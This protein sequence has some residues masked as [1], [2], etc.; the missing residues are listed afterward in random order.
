[1]IL[2]WFH[3]DFLRQKVGYQFASDSFRTCFF[4]TDIFRIVQLLGPHFLV[5]RKM[6]RK[7]APRKRPNSKFAKVGPSSDLV[8]KKQLCTGAARA[9]ANMQYNKYVRHFQQTNECE[10][11][12]SPEFLRIVQLFLADRFDA[13]STVSSNRSARTNKSWTIRAN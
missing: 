12:S 13:Y 11:A 8:Q 1:M 6:Y 7:I 10:K 4:L 9:C 3:V 5:S 2:P